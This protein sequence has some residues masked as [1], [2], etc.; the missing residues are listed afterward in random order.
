MLHD[1][2]CA[3]KP[4]ESILDCSVEG[5]EISAR[6]RQEPVTFGHDSVD[7]L[8]SIDPQT[9]LLLGA[10]LPQMM[11]SRIVRRGLNQEARPPATRIGEQSAETKSQRPDLLHP[12]TV[13]RAQLDRSV[14]Q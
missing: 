7:V 9:A 1:F 14:L 2:A 5:T 3:E 10:L 11:C 12:L 4:A 6:D 13:S 8:S